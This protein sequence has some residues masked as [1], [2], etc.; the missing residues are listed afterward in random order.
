M[1]HVSGDQAD[2]R[3]EVEAQSA[4]ILALVA[5]LTRRFAAEEEEQWRWIA[6]HSPNPH[7]VEIMRDSTITAMRVLDAIGRMEPVNGITVATRSHIPKGTVS[8]VTRRLMTQKL[9]SSSSLPNNRKEVI[10]RLTPLGREFVDF[11][12]R[13][14]GQMER[15]FKNFLR[16]YDAGVLRLLVQILREAN[17]A[18]FLTFEQR[19]SS[20]EPADAAPSGA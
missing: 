19:E 13:F 15:G 16:R 5:Q 20:D 11:H 7:I 17:E 3:A 12:R 6:A 8:K 4:A 14:D 18:S 9:L 1:A 2:D 10:F